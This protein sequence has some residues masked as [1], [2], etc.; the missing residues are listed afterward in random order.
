MI[1]FERAVEVFAEGF[2]YTRSR[3]HPY[4]CARIAP[5][6]LRLHDAPRRGGTPRNEEHLAY[7]VEPSVVHELARTHAAGRFVVCY[8]LPEGGDECG[9]RVEFKALGYRLVATEVLFVHDLVETTAVAAPFPVTRVTTLAER[10]TFHTALGKGLLTDASLTVDPPPI[11]AYVAWDADRPIGWG[12]SVHA[13]GC[14]WVTD[15]WTELEFRR[16]GVARSLMARLLEDD[17]EQGFAA[18]VLLASH[19][20]A[21]LYPTVGYR[22]VG[23]LLMYAPKRE[24]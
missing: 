18:S 6:V 7:G 11:R 20:G 17:R 2:C 23:K 1:R 24:K 22:K 12:A 10:E 5:G 21:L 4:L 19:T 9:L 14:G 15:V 13:E 8:L 16:R 3:T